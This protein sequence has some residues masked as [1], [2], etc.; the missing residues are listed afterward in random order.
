MIRLA[1]TSDLPRIMDV[2]AASVAIMRE[3]GIYQWDD[4][5]PVWEDFA[6]DIA[7]GSLYVE[8]H[9][10][11]VRGVICVDGNEPEDYPKLTWNSS[12][13]LLVVHRFVTDPGCRRQ[14][15]GGKLLRFALD[16]AR[17]R[18]CKCLRT[19]TSA[20]NPAMRALFESQGLVEV[21]EF[22]YLDHKDPYTGYEVIF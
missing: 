1:Q 6:R 8:E 11:L 22:M 5:Y 18:G 7:E 14:G 4:S 16:L 3:S 9:D 15:V 12:P 17:D 13:P 19:D 21:G 2:T 10:G 20:V